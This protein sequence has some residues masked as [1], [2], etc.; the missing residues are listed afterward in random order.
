MVDI[1]HK[2]LFFNI[3]GAFIIDEG[4]LK[5]LKTLHVSGD[6]FRANNREDRMRFNVDLGAGALEFECLAGIRVFDF[7]PPI[8]TL[9]VDIDYIEVYIDFCYNFSF[10]L[11]AVLHK[12]LLKEAKG[13]RLWISGLGFFNWILNPFI[14]LATMYYKKSI[15]NWIQDEVEDEINDGFYRFQFPYS[16]I[17]PLLI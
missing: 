3:T 16:F 2:F 13:M 11:E 4:I 7:K 8:F 1:D 10:G 9:H 15:L 14:R 17:Q 6:C 5:G 12:V